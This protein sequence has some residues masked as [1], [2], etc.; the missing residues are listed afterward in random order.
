MKM[1]IIGYNTEIGFEH[2][3]IDECNKITIRVLISLPLPK[4]AFFL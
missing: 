2:H 3:H 4:E 1:L